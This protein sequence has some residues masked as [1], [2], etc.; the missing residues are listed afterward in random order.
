M[1]NDPLISEAH[2]KQLV[3]IETMSPKE[4]QQLIF[5]QWLPA[6]T[7]SPF[8]Q[9]ANLTGQPAISLPTSIS[10]GGLPM[11]IQFM[12]TKGNERLLLQIANLFEQSQLLKIRDGEQ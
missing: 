1:A 12:A 9:Q 10:A 6:L 11:G 7:R 2:A 4:Q 8:T 5:D 3:S